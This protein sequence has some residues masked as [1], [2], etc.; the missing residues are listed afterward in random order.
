MDI[1]TLDSKNALSLLYMLVCDSVKNLRF[2]FLLP[3]DTVLFSSP[4][5]AKQKSFL[6]YSSNYNFGR[7]RQKFPTKHLH[8]GL[9]YT[10]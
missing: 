5:S 2:E 4:T 1:S 7:S 10:A 3:C 6:V 8:F 9:D